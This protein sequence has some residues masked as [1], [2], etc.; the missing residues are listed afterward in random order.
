MENYDIW[1]DQ[2][3]DQYLET[4]VQSRLKSAIRYALSGTGKRLRPKLML[5]TI[6]ARGFNAKDYASVALALEL[7]HTYSLV[8][9]DLPAMDDDAL[10]RGQP[11]THIQFDEATA[12]LVGDALLSDAFRLISEA[13]QISP[14]KQSAMIRILAEKIGSK[15]MV[16]GQILDIASENTSGD[17]AQLMA[18]NTHKTAHLL[19]AAL[20]MGAIASNESNLERT[21]QLGRDLGLL[22][23]I[24]DDLLE[25]TSDEATAGKSFSDDRR[26][27]PTYLTVLGLA[28]TQAMNDQYYASIQASLKALE[29]EHTVLDELIQTIIHRTY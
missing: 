15:G 18:I 8:H 20:M 3:I 12:I 16:Y 11:T 9:D 27:K 7:V 28:K 14:D 5:A 13:A 19:E 1:I 24:Q 29:L 6:E 10:R 23:Q 22:Y 25:A 4:L 21:E 17:V 26:K 2:A